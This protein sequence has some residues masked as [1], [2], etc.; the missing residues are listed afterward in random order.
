MKKV[1]ISI[2]ATAALATLVNAGKNKDM[3]TEPPIPVPLAPEIAPKTPAPTTTSTPPLGL[4]I[5]GGFTYAHTECECDELQTTDGV[6]TGESTGDTYGINL[7]AGYDFNQFIGVEA[8][9][10]Y[11]PWGDE[12]KTLKHYGLYLKPTYGVTDNIDVYGLVG[13]GKTECDYQDIDEKG[14][15]WGVGAEYLVNKKDKG[16]KKG[17]GIYA[18]YSQ[19]LRKDDDK[20]IKTNL[21]SVGVS[22]HY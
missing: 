20:D 22:F 19:P 18:E 1:L 21:G 15:G 17:W 5:G 8:R 7:R 9:Y 13:Y 14:F 2:V 12:D 16:A 3:A 4:Y 11:T 6:T 10:I